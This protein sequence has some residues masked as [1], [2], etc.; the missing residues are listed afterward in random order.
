[1]N[2]TELESLPMIVVVGPTA[3][4]KSALAVGLAR[5]G[6]SAA[7][8]SGATRPWTRRRPR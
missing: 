4:G 5:A 2:K 3:S 1:M 7:V 8:V 6:I